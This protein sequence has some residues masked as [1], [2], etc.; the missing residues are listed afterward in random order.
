MKYIYALGLLF[1]ISCSFAGRPPSEITPVFPLNGST[2]NVFNL[3]LIWTCENADNYQVFVGKSEDSMPLV[4]EQ[5]GTFYE[6]KNLDQNTVYCWKIIAINDTDTKESGILTFKTGS[7]PDPVVNL[8]KPENGSEMNE[9]DVLLIWEK[10]MFAD[11]YYVEVSHD[12]LF[13]NMIYA[14]VSPDTVCYHHNF[15]A[16]DTLYW[17]VQSLNAFGSSLFSGTHWFITINFLP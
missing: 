13:I 14:G 6:L 2:E 17:H 3:E 5:I 10:A 12:S 11:S 9:P 1:F 4:S 7:L 15:P 8:L 16:E